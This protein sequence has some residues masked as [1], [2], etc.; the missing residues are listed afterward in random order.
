MSGQNK[1]EDTIN[2]AELDGVYDK[3]QAEMI[4]DH[5]AQISNQYEPL[6]NEHFQEYLEVSKIS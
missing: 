6:K 2:V 1:T 3:L 5:Y 4:A